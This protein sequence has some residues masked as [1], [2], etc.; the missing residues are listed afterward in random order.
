MRKILILFSIL[1]VPVISNAQMAVI[2]AD[3][4]AKSTIQIEELRKS[5]AKLQEQYLNSVD[6]L[7][8]MTDLHKNAI[9]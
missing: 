5:Y 9:E 3:S 2:D 7:K 6:Q 4:I 1:L 8:E